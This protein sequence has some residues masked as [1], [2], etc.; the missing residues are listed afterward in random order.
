M[1]Y[2]VNLE[3]LE[4]QWIAHVADLPG[5]FAVGRTFSAALAQTSTAIANYLAWLHTHGEAIDPHEVTPELG[6]VHRAWSTPGGGEANAFFATDRVPLTMGEITRLSQL[7]E[8]TR[9]DLLAVVQEVKPAELTQ[10]VENQW[11][12]R[13]ILNHLGRG[14]RWYLD[15]LDL[16]GDSP[17]PE[18]MEQLRVVRARLQRL[19]PSFANVDRV[20][21]KDL[22]LWS[23]RKLLRRAL[24][25]E[26]DHTAHIRQFLRRLRPA[27]RPLIN[28][29]ASEV[30]P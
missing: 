5:C 26:R 22:E 6:E 14:E 3:E 8:W 11:A 19:M 20:V 2:R 17:P 9:A 29:P 16:A 12:I 21:V 13:D 25:H 24:W 27:T 30:T 7:L 15:R 1:V 23:P 10:A 28:F 18:V 4:G